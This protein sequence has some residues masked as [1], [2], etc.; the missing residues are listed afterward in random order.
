[1]GKCNVTFTQSNTVLRVNETTHI[2]SLCTVAYIPTVLF[3]ECWM[4]LRMNNNILNE[5]MNIQHVNVECV[6]VEYVNVEHVNVE[7]VNVEYVNN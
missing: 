1:M 5:L 3:Y 6:N 4:D 7:H 2:V